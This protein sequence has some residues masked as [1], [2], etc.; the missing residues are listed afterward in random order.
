MLH[1][2]LNRT[3]LRG[4]SLTRKFAILVTSVICL[5]LIALGLYFDSF[6][7]KS[8]LHT[9][10]SRMRH[11]FDTIQHR[12]DDIEQELIDGIQFIG[13]HTPTIASLNLLQR[14]EDRKNYN[15]FL[16]DE[17]KKSLTLE[18]LRRVKLSFNTHIL[19]YNHNGE[20]VSYVIKKADGYHLN[21][22][23]YQSGK[24]ELYSR[25]EQA[26][27][28]NQVPISTLSLDQIDYLH[29]D[30]YISNNPQALTYNYN[31]NA[32][33]IRSHLSLNSPQDNNLFAHIEMWKKLDSQYFSKLGQDLNIELQ[34]LP[35][36]QTTKPSGFLSELEQVQ[37]IAINQSSHNY[38]SA[39]GIKADEA[40]VSLLASLDKA[41][42]NQALHENREHLLAIIILIALLS[43]I[44]M[45]VFIKRLVYKPLSIVM[46]QVEKIEQQDYSRS[47]NLQTADEFEV[48]SH[49][50]NELA[51]TVR[52]REDSLEQ[53]K[54]RMEYLSNHDALTNLPNRR[55]FSLRLEH[56]LELARRN[57][58]Q[59]ALFFI[60]L[61]QFK[62]VNDTQ[63]HIV[64]DQLLE[65]VAE[66]LRNHVRK[67]DTL[68]RIGGDEFNLLIEKV[69]SIQQLETIADHYLKLIEQ[70]FSVAN[71][72][73]NISAS[74][75][76][77]VFPQDGTDSVTLIKNADMAMYKSKELGR[78]NFCFFS[79][80]L[81]RIVNERA[82]ITQA[83]REALKTKE[84]FSLLYQPKVSVTTG[85]I[86]S[87]EALIR[88]NRPGYG[89]ISPAAFI[90][91]AEEYGYISEM[92]GWVLQQACNDFMQLAK[93][94]VRLRYIGVNLSNI[95]LSNR[96]FIA[97]LSRIIDESG[98]RPEQLELEITESYLADDLDDAIHTLNTLRT[99]GLGI[100][101]DDFGTGYSAMSYLQKL[102]VTRL[103]V[104]KS[105]VDDLPHDDNS[106]ALVRAIIGLAK[107]F[108]L[109]L[110]AEG[111][112][113]EAQLNFLIKEGCDEIQGYYYS[114]P[115]SFS[116]LTSFY[117][118]H[119][120]SNVVKLHPNK[121]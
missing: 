43:L 48:I 47:A 3:K 49:S 94:G 96:N 54:D 58:E 91:V 39:I 121:S 56:A 88:W 18:L 51:K 117:H 110:T 23:T 72:V 22:I 114:K 30:Y 115:L 14:Y 74:V 34:L 101:I 37:T 19:L 24:P 26:D 40:T 113:N 100:A 86:V 35:T 68:A 87:V 9:T 4:Q 12:F 84:E 62:Q 119:H 73:L 8:F 98:I 42:L 25:H 120:S 46:N 107:S 77:S 118:Q 27:S 81:S 89:L 11:A 38:M 67:S 106:I 82:S 79:D 104:D 111:V 32:L 61:D 10:E 66:R 97:N 53:S 75:G 41:P 83:L 52:I 15:T 13:Q 70:P 105:F 7:Q 108:D 45:S 76:I 85:E 29:S 6:L 69:E 17:E 1:A 112:E 78:D 57:N 92:G 16:I 80:D 63:G 99:M 90:P 65:R 5:L 55:F 64:G 93:Q 44:L 59:L 95:Q 60:D 21:Y 2:N 102:P 50:I 109:A 20:L 116:E 28:F 31:N 71:Q 33:F 36:T 103:K